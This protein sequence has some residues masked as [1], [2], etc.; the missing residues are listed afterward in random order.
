MLR[1]QIRELRARLDELYREA[2][3]SVSAADGS[4]P[5]ELASAAAFGKLGREQAK[6]RMQYCFYST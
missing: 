3:S 6:A 2:F 5:V 4:S 1:V